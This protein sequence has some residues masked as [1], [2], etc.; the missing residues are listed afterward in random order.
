MKTCKLMQVK[1]MGFKKKVPNGEH[2]HYD[3]LHHG[4][5]KA[6]FWISVIH[7]VHRNVAMHGYA[8]R[9]RP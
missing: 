2:I 1:E 4:N 7:I 6:I 9:Y 5:K 8:Y 3:F